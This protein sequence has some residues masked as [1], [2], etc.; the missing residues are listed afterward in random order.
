LQHGADHQ[1]R[2][3]CERR[4]AARAALAR[5][6]ERRV[7]LLLGAAERPAERA[8]P[9][10][11]HEPGS[12]SAGI[13]R[14]E[15]LT[16][17]GRQ[18]GSLLGGELIRLPQR[19]VHRQHVLVVGK[20]GRAGDRAFEALRRFGR[21][22]EPQD[23]LHRSLPLRVGQPHEAAVDRRAL[24]AHRPRLGRAVAAG[25]AEAARAHASRPGEASA[26]ARRQ[27]AGR[28]AIAAPDLT[29]A[30]EEQRRSEQGHANTPLR[31]ASG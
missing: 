14:G 10:L 27:H 23:V 17:G 4:A 25:S 3:P 5:S 28:S 19:V 2:A 26:C 22:A 31:T 8:P 9:E 7:A 6:E 16:R 12:V 30:R 15:R 11:L 20:V 24:E 18:L 13:E 21:H 29:A 1:R